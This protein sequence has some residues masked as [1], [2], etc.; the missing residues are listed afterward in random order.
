MFKS[1][2]LMAVL[3]ICAALLPVAGSPFPSASAAPLAATVP[4]LGTA[5]SFAVLGASTVT[6]TGNSIVNG[7]LGVSPGTAIT[8]FP[9]GIVNGTTHAGGAVAQQAQSD[10]TAA[11]NDLAGQACNN[12]LTGQD[13]GGKTLTPGVYCFDSSAG[14]TGALVLDAQFVD[15]SVW[16]FK[17]GSTLTTASGSSVTVINGSS[18]CNVWWQ[19]GASATLGTA[20]TFRGNILALA[21]ITLNTNASMSGAALARTGAVTM[22]TNTINICFGPNAIALQEV[23]ATSAIDLPLGLGAGAAFLLSL[24]LIVVRRR[25]LATSDAMPSTRQGDGK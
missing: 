13:L 12:N 7:N 3:L 24:G 23:Q 15:R 17:I 10:V 20:T 2:R 16:V 8:G 25:V 22:D 1:A 19:V 5:K 21:S 4:P 9:P 6:N 14:L 18:P 11:Y